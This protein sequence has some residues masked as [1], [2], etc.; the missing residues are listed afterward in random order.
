MGA[1]RATQAATANKV[2]ENMATMA[3][4]EAKPHVPYVYPS[5]HRILCEEKQCNSTSTAIV[6]V[7]Q[8]LLS[9]WH[10]LLGEHTGQACGGTAGIE[11]LERHIPRFR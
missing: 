6:V 9:T 5:F 4:G 3:G 11:Q 1:A 10:T 2:S 7:T 8:P